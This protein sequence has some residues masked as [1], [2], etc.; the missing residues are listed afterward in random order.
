MSASFPSNQRMSGGRLALI[1]QYQ[2]ILPAPRLQMAA[3]QSAKPHIR[4]M[5]LRPGKAPLQ[6]CNYAGEYGPGICVSL[7]GSQGLKSELVEPAE[8]HSC[9]VPT[10]TCP[11]TGRVL[12]VKLQAGGGEELTP[13]ALLSPGEYQ[14]GGAE[15]A[16]DAVR[17]SRS[18]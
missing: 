2:M 13:P 6:G 1:P 9:D 3:R 18:R 17:R 16:G 15:F 14:G 11:R 10:F 4:F 12:I 7:E 5:R 8:V